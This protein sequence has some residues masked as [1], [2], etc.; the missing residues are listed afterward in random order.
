MNEFSQARRLLEAIGPGRLLLVGPD[1]E[2]LAIE[3]RRL[4]CDVA[5]CDAAHALAGGAA[6]PAA[7]SF[8][9]VIWSWKSG[10]RIPSPMALQRLAG[11]DVRLLALVREP[12]WQ[13][14]PATTIR[15]LALE[16]GWRRSLC[17]WNVGHYLALD[18]PGAWTE[19]ILEPVPDVCR[20]SREPALPAGLLD[21]TRDVEPAA[22]VWLARYAKAAE[23][24]RPGDHVLVAGARS[25][26]GVALL[27]QRS[28]AARISAFDAS[29]PALAYA[30]AHHAGGDLVRYACAAPHR[31]PSV[32][33]RSVDLVVALDVFDG[34]VDAGAAVAEY[35]R[36][37]K[38]DGRIV[39]GVPN[40]AAPAAATALQAILGE[41]F[42]VEA[43]HCVRGPGPNGFGRSVDR[44]AADDPLPAKG[45]HLIVASCNPLGADA[46]GFAHP[47]FARRLDGDSSAPVPVTDFGAHYDNPWLYRPMVQMGQRLQDEARL[48][49]LAIAAFEAA[50]STSADA[51]AALCV[52]AYQ[53]LSRRRTDQVQNL[54]PLIDA[55]AA[56]PATNPHALR[57][58]ISLEFAAALACMTAGDLP[59]A[60][61][62]LLRV[63]RR[64]P[65][66]FSPLLT[67]KLVAASFW[68]GI[69]R[70]VGRQPDDAQQCFQGGVRAAARALAAPIERSIGSIEQPNTFGFQE[71][72][73]VA[74]MASQ[75]AQALDAMAHF[76]LA[77]GRFWRQVD[78]RRF[79]LASWLLHLERENLE[80][81]QQLTQAATP[82]SHKN[83]AGQH[84]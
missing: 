21:P 59:R 23:L 61:D 62:F 24:V 83:I 30:R 55:Y 11:R 60:E 17:D 18:H 46:S 26:A 69:R 67:T 49:D 39:A 19:L 41:H 64:D 8:D 40:G 10:G 7:P 50:G 1:T 32:D 3:L 54:L 74:D 78:T 34:S 6:V 27:A 35:A 5:P 16:G 51:G 73:E 66:A 37:L 47:E 72:A 12:D 82:P 15:C 42:L 13:A 84:R 71:L 68:L 76:D 4:G 70:L 48:T 44:L 22:D 53:V 29:E 2:A 43:R 77:P 28:R 65:L 9:A 56:Q 25:G 81:R 45:C 58:Q 57:W 20:G 52:L 33:A 75:C 31:L 14:P 80:L 38:P 63:T 36:V 79:G